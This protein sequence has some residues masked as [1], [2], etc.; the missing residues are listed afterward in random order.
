MDFYFDPAKDKVPRR[1][2]P[3]EETRVKNK[4]VS[5]NEADKLVRILSIYSCIRSYS[6]YY[7][8]NNKPNFPLASLVTSLFHIMFE[9]D[10]LFSLKKNRKNLI[11]QI[12]DVKENSNPSVSIVIL[13]DELANLLNQ[14]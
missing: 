9:S 8:D 4:E 10:T 5:V 11:E 3:S 7:M 14:I 2:F 12:R 6:E 1:E 13:I